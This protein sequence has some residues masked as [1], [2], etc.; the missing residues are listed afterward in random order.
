MAD[1]FISYAREDRAQ[2]D[3]LASALEASGYSVWWDKRISAGVEF[4]KETTAELAAARVVLVA[5]SKA[6]SSSHWVADEAAEGRDSG[7]LAPISLDGT[8]P[9]LG[10]R[11]FQTIDFAPWARGDLTPFDELSAAIG[12]KLDAPAR[13][14]AAPKRSFRAP[15]R[16]VLA[17]A[18]AALAL[19]AAGSYLLSGRENAS[20]APEKAAA[21]RPDRK[22]VYGSIAVLPFVD[23]SEQ[24]DHAWFADGVAEEILSDLSRSNGLKVVARSSSFLFRDSKKP[25]SEIAFELGVEAILEGSV[26]RSGDRLRVSAQ[27]IDAN[28]GFQLWSKK[29]DRNADDVFDVQDEISATIVREMNSAL[30]PAPAAGR[31]Q[32]AEAYD[33]FLEAK[34][35]AEQRS[36]ASLKA[37]REKFAEVIRLEPDFAP[38]Y[39]LLA[40]AA[41]RSSIN[42]HGD[43]PH[44]EALALAKRN[45]AKAYQLDPSLIEARA[46]D[47]AVRTLS[48][49]DS[50]N[51]AAEFAA[52][53]EIARKLIA[54]A[55]D[56]LPGY[57]EIV[58]N[59]QAQGKPKD[60][61]VFAEKAIE[62]DPLGAM[63][64]R[65]LST[66]LRFA[67]RSEE[68]AAVAA[69]AMSYNKDSNLLAV[70]HHYALTDHGDIS[71][72]LATIV[73]LLEASPEDFTLR[74]MAS[75]VMAF[76]GFEE[77]AV[78]LAPDDWGRDAALLQLGKPSVGASD[79]V[80][81]PTDNVWN[82]QLRGIRLFVSRKF[83][84]A[85]MPLAKA[86][87]PET[88]SEA[89]LIARLAYAYRE[90][91][92]DAAE[93]D[94]RAKLD[95]LIAQMET[96]GVGDAFYFEAKTLSLALN[97]DADALFNSPEVSRYVKSST[98]LRA[99]VEL[100]PMFESYA[101]DARH[102]R[103]VAQEAAHKRS[104]RREALADGSV[105]RVKAIL[106][107]S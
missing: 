1:I 90:T 65:K 3:L 48:A 25:L 105:E 7:R 51:A 15:S 16:A 77:E 24:K 89:A 56:Y 84:Q 79:A 57:Y 18:A 94:W 49:F 88:V 104:E 66:T 61:L 22:E 55:P 60:A 82:D 32:S 98:A 2:I 100:D 36:P 38:A 34:F 42:D 59:L 69:R 63:S 68:A 4:T 106:A 39:A 9:P 29:F 91:Q 102:A 46:V 75:S 103:L 17:G 70:A 30:K 5:W 21:E 99:P 31:P 101:R 8:P 80:A 58:F 23:L 47:V 76:L 26:R 64:S 44:E 87:A 20:S 86:A 83:P 72:A 73:P 11:Q 97:G 54:E 37:A 53:E 71:G 50:D 74:Q 93:A 81:V 85:I 33:A 67:G 13:P 45:L 10:F 28:T 52:A 95:R 62:I 14:I 78:A 35:L 107:K 41:W 40:D 12:G 19:V 27:L 96:N 43:M 6:S 92:A